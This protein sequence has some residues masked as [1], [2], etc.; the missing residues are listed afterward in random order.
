M[1]PLRS[2][3]IRRPSSCISRTRSATVEVS[4]ASERDTPFTAM[5]TRSVEGAADIEAK[6]AIKADHIASFQAI[7][8]NARGRA[9]DLDG[10]DR[11]PI[12]RRVVRGADDCVGIARCGHGMQARENERRSDAAAANG[13]IDTDRTKV[14][15]ARAVVA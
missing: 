13:G 9:L 1:T 14:V 4:A 7:A 2:T 11:F 5:E 6:R 3:A 10:A 12:E 15:A 8:V